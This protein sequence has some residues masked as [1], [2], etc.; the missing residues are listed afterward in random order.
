MCSGAGGLSTTAETAAQE[1]ESK[2]KIRNRPYR[3]ICLLCLVTSAFIVTV[4]GLSIYVSQIR[5][6]NETCHRNSNL[7]DLTGMHSDLRHQFTEMETKYRSVNETKAQICELLTS[8]REQTCSKDWVT[9]KGRCYYVSTFETSFRQASQECSNRDSRLLEVNTRDEAS[10][11]SR[12]VLYLKYAYWIGKCEVGN[13]SLGLLHNMSPGQSVCID[14]E[15]YV[16]DRPCDRD[17]RFICEKSAPLFPD[18]PEKI[19]GLCQQPVDST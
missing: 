14:C 10:F 16:G 3:L 15:S 17:H 18:I 1:R 9:N 7:P 12:K 4:A 8:R 13:V 6:T 5:Q 19:Q 11:V 2:V